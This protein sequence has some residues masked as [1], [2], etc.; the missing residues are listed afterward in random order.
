MPEANDEQKVVPASMED[1][2]AAVDAM[3]ATSDKDKI[4]KE[5]IKTNIKLAEYLADLAVSLR[6]M[7][8]IGGQLQTKVDEL[9]SRVKA[10]EEKNV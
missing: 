10:L 7:A 3:W 1:K 8:E 4:V 5:T 6:S 9:E 2:L